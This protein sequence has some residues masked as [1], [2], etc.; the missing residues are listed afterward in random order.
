VLITYVAD[1]MHLIFHSL[2]PPTSFEC[3]FNVRSFVISKFEYLSFV[4]VDKILFVDSAL[5]L[6][7]GKESKSGFS[8]PKSFSI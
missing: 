5:L 4:R 3:T 2:N 1:F 6:K 7:S 8:V